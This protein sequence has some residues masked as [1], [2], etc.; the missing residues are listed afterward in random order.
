MGAVEL[1][2]QRRL[3]AD[4]GEGVNEALNETTGDLLRTRAAASVLAVAVGIGV[5]GGGCDGGIERGCCRC[6]GV[7]FMLM[8]GGMTGYP[9]ALRGS[10][11]IPY[12]LGGGVVVRGRHFLSVGS[13]RHALHRSL[14]ESLHNQ[15]VV[16][17]SHHTWA[18]AVADDGAP[19]AVQ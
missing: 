4:D 11:D 10:K 2:I 17:L 19:P 16:R 18:T 12:R 9:T 13:P 5:G 8:I 7:D 3:L 14:Q 1:L 6:S 15:P